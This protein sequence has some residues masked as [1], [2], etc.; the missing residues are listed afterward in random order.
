MTDRHVGSR[1]ITTRQRHELLQVYFNMGL[2]VSRILCVEYGVARDYAAKQAS[3]LGL[4][5]RA[6]SKIA[7]RTQACR[8]DHND[9]RWK[10]AAQRGSITA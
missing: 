5:I 4:C 8:I 3:E 7:A 9:P 2:E 1:K 6:R 10:L